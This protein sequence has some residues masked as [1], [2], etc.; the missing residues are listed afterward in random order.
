MGSKRKN[1]YGVR[2]GRIPGVYNDWEQC[3]AQVDKCPNQFQGFNTYD[4]AAFFVETGK[5]LASDEGKSLFAKWKRPAL[6][7]ISSNNAEMKLRIRLE[8]LDASQ[9]YFSQV[10]NF[11]PDDKA[12]PGSK[13]WRQQRTSAIRHEMIFHYSQQVDS[14]SSDDDLDEE[15]QE[16]KERL[17]RLHTYQNMCREVDLEPLDT[18]DDCVANL[19]SVL[20]NI[21]D[22]IDARR[23]NKPIK[24]WKP[25]QFD[26]FKAYTLTREKRIDREEAK[27][28]DGFLAALLQDFRGGVHLYLKRRDAAIVAREKCASR[29]SREVKDRQPEPQLPAIKEESSIGNIHDNVKREYEVISIHGSESDFSSPCSSPARVIK[30]ENVNSAPSSSSSIASSVVGI[31]C[32]PERGRKRK[33]HTPTQ[34]ESFSE[35]ESTSTGVYKRARRRSIYSALIGV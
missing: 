32:L 23:N 8:A 4:E 35:D 22:Y 18:I 6:S 2:K 9:S 25:Q 33:P 27:S 5:T 31:P 34:I 13:A 12:A 28:G 1:Y 20:V 3:R 14:D 16:E 29:G 26:S 21:I 7:G 11:E 10:P 19:K 24:V 15:E 30:K 17:R